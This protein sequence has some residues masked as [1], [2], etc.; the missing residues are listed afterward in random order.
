MNLSFFSYLD[1]IAM[2]NK[3]SK[4]CLFIF[5]IGLQ[6]IYGQSSVNTFLSKSDS[7]NPK[8]FYP[9]ATFSIVAYTGFS[10]GL[11]QAWY[12]EFDQGNFHFFNDSGAWES[13]DKVGHGYTA[14]FQ[15]VLGYKGASWTGLNKNNSILTGMLMG[16]IFQGTIEVMDGFADKWGFSSYDMLFNFGGTIAFS[17]QQYFW[18]EQRISFKISSHPVT[19]PDENISSLDGLQ[20]TSLNNRA[21]SLF[22]DSYMAKYLK[23]YN[24]Q[25]YWMSVNPASFLAENTRFPSWL[26]I[27]VGYSAENLFGGFENEWKEGNASFVLDQNVY[28]R[29]QQFF[30]ALDYDFWQIRTKWAFANTILDILNI[31]KLPA[32]AIEF[33]SLGEVK[34]HLF[35]F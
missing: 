21:S 11:Y 10:Y 28:P 29:Y 31:F 33:N 20:M 13:M 5:A 22:G 7:L 34:L 23:D 4:I 27:A 30:L 6:N 14:Y 17:A 2:L 19:Y 12:K 26:N 16:T 18:D 24:G 15:G 25:T 35:Y 3:I 32:P 9:A 8:R 1:F